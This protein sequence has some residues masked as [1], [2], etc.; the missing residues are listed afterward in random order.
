MKRDFWHSFPVTIASIAI[1]FVFRVY[2]AGLYGKEALGYFYTALDVVSL[3]MMAFIGFRAS[4]TVEYAKHGDAVGIL[5]VLRLFVIGVVLL[6]CI[7]L[8]PWMR[9]HLGVSLSEFYLY[10]LFGSYAAYTYFTNQLSMYR[11]YR[12]MNVVTLLEPAALCIWFFIAYYL[13]GLHGD[14]A[15]AVSSI[16]SLVTTALYVAA[17]VAKTHPEPPLRRVCLSKEECGFVKNSMMA[18]AEFVFG[19]LSMYLAVYV[20][21]RYHTPSQ[22]GDF[23]VV[24]KTVLMYCIMLFVFPIFKFFLPEIASYVRSNDREKLDALEIWVQKYALGVALGIFAVHLLIGQ[25]AVDRL[26]GA[27]YGDSYGALLWLLPMLYLIVLN[28][29]QISVIKAFGRFGLSMSVRAAGGAAFVLFYPLIRLVDDSLTSVVWAM[30]ASYVTM[31]LL[32]F[33]IARSLVSGK[34]WG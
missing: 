4:M 2:L 7:L 27:A 22:L 23:Q 28:V 25:W 20:L 15:L 8:V 31:S 10:A 32:S 17:K 3:A 5:N 12:T 24:V 13:L 11:L 1:L 6:C 26:F 29:Y 14:H 21:T 34:K 30:D 19:M 18:S 33:F 16:M 9:L